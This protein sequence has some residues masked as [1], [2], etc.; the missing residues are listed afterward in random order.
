MFTHKF[1][2]RRT[3]LSKI[4][5]TAAVAC[6]L[7]ATVPAIGA[8]QESGSH[9]AQLDARWQ[10]W[11]GCWRPAAPQTPGVTFSAPRNSDAPLVC[12]VPAAGAA[13]PSSSVNVLTVSN[14]KIVST[15]TIDA[16]GRNVARS[17]DGCTGVENAAWSTDGRRLYVTSDF[18]CPG[19]LK[20]TS[21]G[22]FAM[23]PRGDWVN[24]Q[25]VDAGGN[26]GVHTLHYTDAGIPSALPGEISQALHA[27]GLSVTTARAAAGARLTT[28]NVVEASHKLDPVV[29][30][31][32]VIDRGQ[33][34]GLDANQ[35][36]ALADAG[37]PGNVTDAMVAVTY[38]KAFAV[39]R[40][41]GD[42]DVANIEAV[43]GASGSNVNAVDRGDVRV[44]M[45]PG[46]S[47]Y[48]YSPFGYSPYD[49]YG[50]GYSPYGY[51][52][53]GYAPYGYSPYGGS[54]SPYA[55][56]GAAYGG[57]YSPPI[58]ILKGNATPALPHGTAVKGRGYTRGSPANGSSSGSNG[59]TA[60][61]RPTVSSPPA[62]PA[63][64]PSQPAST[65]RTAHER[66]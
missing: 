39:N 45:M 25:G 44:M 18:T 19:N 60:S 52:P 50:Y 58:I 15:D 54:Y 56:Y 7:V 5:A 37:V 27:H 49:Y 46:Y 43:Q 6:G 11:V 8:A 33:G 21:S 24:I 51:S 53:F 2:E 42:S 63:P 17:K 35:I 1:L 13:S 16:T 32:W 48:N 62:Q 3:R 65:G 23:S 59:S 40:S 31:A 30:E 57:W 29:V 20:R 22:L 61:P 10:P 28:A 64:K 55:G 9:T 4:V 38:P 66:P 34:F 47:R 41:N 26:K 12:V 36:V 14:G